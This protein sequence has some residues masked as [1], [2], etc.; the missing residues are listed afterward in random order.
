MDSS[1]ASPLSACGSAVLAV[2]MLRRRCRSVVYLALEEVP[3]RK[4]KHGVGRAIVGVVRGP[5]TIALVP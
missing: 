3:R 5:S 4:K 2:S 1:S